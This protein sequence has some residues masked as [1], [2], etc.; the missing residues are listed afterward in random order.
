MRDD[1]RIDAELAERVAQRAAVRSTE[2]V[3]CGRGRQRSVAE[4]AELTRATIR[5]RSASSA[6]SAAAS[7][8]S[9]FT[10]GLG[11]SAIGDGGDAT[12]DG[13]G[14]GVAVD[15][16]TGAETTTGGGGTTTGGAS[17]DA[18]SRG[19]CARARRH[20]G[21]RGRRRCRRRNAY[22]ADRQRLALGA[23]DGSAAV[24]AGCDRVL[25]GRLAAS[26][27]G[28]SPRR[29]WI[30]ARPRMA[31]RF[32]GADRSTS[33]ARRAPRRSRPSLDQRASERDPR[34]QVGRMPLET[35]R[36]VSIASSNGRRGGT[37]P[38][39][40][41]TRST[42]GPAGPGASIPRSE[43]CPPCRRAGERPRLR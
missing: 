24:D 8:C 30:S 15:T 12:T 17:R 40:P 1:E 7:G 41:Q 35:G 23:G 9:R 18:S 13:G 26:V 10:T 2:T 37:P 38:P 43:D 33:R 29:W 4:A 22:R 31:A 34:G 14:A 32:S 3:D 19:A 6:G 28:I 25:G 27:S 42:P 39:A 11:S 16:D 5:A 36:Q 21:L 20:L